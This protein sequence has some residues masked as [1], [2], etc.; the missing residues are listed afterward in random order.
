LP[1]PHLLPPPPTASRHGACVWRRSQT[2]SRRHPI[3]L[4]TTLLPFTT[5]IS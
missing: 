2:R 3:A 5:A 4:T 1:L